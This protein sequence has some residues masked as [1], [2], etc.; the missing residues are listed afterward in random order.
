MHKFKIDTTIVE[1][2]INRADMNEYRN[3]EIYLIGDNNETNIFTM[4]NNPNYDRINLL[5]KRLINVLKYFKLSNEAKYEMFIKED[6]LLEK[7]III[8]LVVGM[9]EKYKKIFRATSDGYNNII[10]DLANYSASINSY[11]E[12]IED[13]EDYLGY[14]MTLLV[15]D[16]KDTNMIKTSINAFEHAL[17]CTSYACYISESNQLNFIRNLNILE[18]W[19]FLEFDV[20]SKVINRKKYSSK[21]ALEYL[22]MAI[23]ANPEMIIL[24]V[25]GKVFLEK[26]DLLSAQKMYN[27]G[28]RKFLENVA[29]DKDLN[30]LV[31]V[32]KSLST[33]KYL[34]N[35]MIVLWLVT[36]IVAIFQRRINLPF[37][38][39]FLLIM[40]LFIL[41]D[42]LKHKLVSLTTI[43]YFLR[44]TCY[45]LLSVV[46]WL[47]FQ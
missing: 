40:C 10:I 13:I 24:G 34:I 23:Y 33:I 3:N 43:N 22:D 37:K 19:I 18:M 42:T 26:M 27:A 35:P 47:I 8:R 21:H 7:K 5:T 29:K 41:K 14:A 17:Y 6:V 39:I 2:F 16:N 20:L 38:I 36:C 45:L 9:P 4:P 12:I 25:T 46:F 28:T 11:E 30:F 32:M 1:A 44:I 31:K 15:L